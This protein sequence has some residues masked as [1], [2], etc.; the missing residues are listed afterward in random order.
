MNTET[1]Q[2]MK[3]SIRKGRLNVKGIKPIYP[4]KI[5]KETKQSPQKHIMSLRTSSTLSSN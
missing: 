5:I 1:R 4:P 3:V 2:K